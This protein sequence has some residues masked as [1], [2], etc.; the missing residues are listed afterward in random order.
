[1][2][3]FGLVA[4]LLGLMSIPA[5]AGL[6]YTTVPGSDNDG[7]LSAQVTINAVNGGLDIQITN[8]ETG[9]VKR[10]Q[11]ISALSF[12]LSG[13]AAPT[14]LTEIV[15]EKVNSTAF[16]AGH[17]FPGTAT[18]THVD[19]HGSAKILDH[20]GLS[21]GS[22]DY[23]ATAGTGSATGNPHYMI[24]P[25]S[26]IA[27]PGNSLRQ[28]NFDPYLIGP[29]DFF[30]SVPGVTKNTQLTLAEFSNL[31]VGF[32]TGPDKWLGTVGHSDH[33]SPAS[34]PEPSSMAL[35]LISLAGMV[36]YRR[37]SRRK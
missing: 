30:I 8:L 16:T 21:I 17:A 6:I 32:G 9:I 15:G 34:V 13:L 26:G 1:M 36:C 19:D 37:W 3:W 4:L 31:Q 25:S 23:L 29:T 14:A 22:T 11:A 35:A 27:G 24:L 12:K 28:S 20:W 5:R 10:G 18:L 7:P 33:L 2:R